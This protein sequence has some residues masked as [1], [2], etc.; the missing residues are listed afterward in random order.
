MDF[1]RE[2]VA[3]LAAQVRAGQVS[4]REL[5][6]AALER[7]EALNGDVNAFVAV[8]AELALADAAAV[9]DAVAAG[10]EVGPLAGI[11]IGVKDLEHAA[12]FCTT[13]GSPAHEDDPP[14]TVD[15]EL[16]ARLKQA[17][18]VVVGKTNTPEYGHKGDTSNPVFGSTGNPWDL[19][20]SAGGSSGGTAAALASGMVPLATGSDG[21]GSIRIPASV[22]GFSG[23]K[24]SLGR[25]PYTEARP[26]SWPDLS[27]KGPMALRV[28]D[29]TMAFDAVIGPDPHDMRA[30]PMPA[31]AWGPATAEPHAP[32]KVGWAPTLGYGEVDAEVRQV[33]EGAV[34]ALAGLGTEV[35]EVAALW[36]EDPVGAFLTMGSV[37][38]LRHLEQFRG[39]EAWDRF[40]PVFVQILE[41]GASRTALQLHRAQDAGHHLNQKLVALFHDVDLLL[42][43]TCAGQ[44]PLAGSGEGRIN[45]EPALNW[46]QNTYGFNLTRSPAG[47]VCAGLTADGM[48]VGLQVVGPQHGDVAVLRLMATLEQAIGFDQLAPTGSGTS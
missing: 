46:V 22:N 42:S 25:V 2:T 30:L 31:A 8:D 12:G 29:I 18:C 17:G 38:N 44:V 6:E 47:T 13:H 21:G 40:D 20:R 1:R 23:F 27:V 34:D 5:A 4:A 43:P 19:R 7:I 39:T 48:P 26:P 10:E 15:S 41:W 35:V 11:P 3:D 9:D 33:C 45:G 14:A 37:G 24:P 36:D 16:V 28:A 32:R